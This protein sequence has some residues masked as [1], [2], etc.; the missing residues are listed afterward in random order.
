M[1]G[2]AAESRVL[3]LGVGNILW[4]DEGFGVRCVETF[5]ERFDV[6]DRV[7]V[8]DGGTQGLLLIDPLREADRVI[9]FDAIDFGGV[10]GEMRVVRDDAIPAFVGARAMSLHQTGMTDV[11][12]LASLLGWK[13]DAVTL[14]GVQP[15]LLEDYGGSLTPEVRACIDPALDV[16]LSELA[17]WGVPV[18]ARAAFG[19]DAD[20]LA[21]A[22]SLDRYEQ[23][24]PSAEAACRHGDERVLAAAH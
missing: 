2:I 16:A 17:R 15:V 5:G 18:S 23:G 20:V 6:P 12:A 1:S 9:L 13:P 19:A 3:L 7:T 22:L 24:R 21:P 10:P 14:I 8:L 4:A 11:L